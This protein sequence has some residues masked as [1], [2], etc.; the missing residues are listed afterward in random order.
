[1]PA[2]LSATEA[3]VSMTVFPALHHLYQKATGKWLFRRESPGTNTHLFSTVRLVFVDV[4]E[5]P[6]S[7][8]WTKI[9]RPDVSV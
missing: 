6:G 5:L 2:K 3:R 4:H 7:T 8:S 9:E 1:M